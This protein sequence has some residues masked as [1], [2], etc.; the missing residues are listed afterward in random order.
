VWCDDFSGLD[1]T[2]G[3]GTH[4]FIH[5]NWTKVIGRFVPPYFVSDY[6]DTWLNEVALA[7]NVQTFLPHHITEH[8][9]HNFG[10][11]EVDAN[12]LE[13]LARH[14]EQRPEDIYKNT[15]QERR[16]EV[17]KLSAYIARMQVATAPQCASG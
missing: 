9:H 12:T 8:M 16:E 15:A 13:R 10:K 3:F 6:N 4:G 5:R 7:L 11:A 14:E 2:P 1:T 17:A